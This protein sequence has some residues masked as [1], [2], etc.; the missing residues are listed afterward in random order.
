MCNLYRMT[1]TPDEI[2]KLFDVELVAGGNAGDEVY[3][4][5]PGLVVAEGQLRTMHWGFPLALHGKHGQLLK[6]KP[7]NNARTDRLKGPFWRAS[8]I[9]RRCLIPM[10]G[11]AEAEGPKGQKTRSWI[12][13]PDGEPFAAAGIWRWS[14]EWGEVY[15]MVLTDAA[16]AAREVHTRMPVLIRHEDYRTYLEAGSEEAF[17]LCRPYVAELAL[18]RTDQLWGGGR[19]H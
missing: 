18:E 15:S 16:G 8:F 5:H 7:V 12:G 17:A 13:M 9:K 3:P 19:A 11:Y 1:R 4:G 10:T 2:A 6:P 14:D